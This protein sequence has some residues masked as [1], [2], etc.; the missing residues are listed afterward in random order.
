MGF[1]LLG[2]V[3]KAKEYISIKLNYS[4]I[5]ILK[6]KTNGIVTFNKGASDTNCIIFTEE[7]E[8][9]SSNV[10]GIIIEKDISLF[11]HIKIRKA[12]VIS[13]ICRDSEYYKKLKSSVSEGS[14][15]ELI[16]TSD[17]IILNPFFNNQK[18]ESIY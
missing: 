1:P 16:I 4:P 18:L 3:I 8:E 11:T 15:F 10:K 9:I 13:A 14:E 7:I 5:T 6:G 12:N 17:S 2:L